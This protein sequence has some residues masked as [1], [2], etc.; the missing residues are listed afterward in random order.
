MKSFE[1]KIFHTLTI[2]LLLTTICLSLKVEKLEDELNTCK[3]SKGIPTVSDSLS[4]GGYC[5]VERLR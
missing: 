1:T 3:S 2:V 5:C 4:D